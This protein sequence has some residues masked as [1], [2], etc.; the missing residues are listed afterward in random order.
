MS[1][2]EALTQSKPRQ[3][4]DVKDAALAAAAN[5]I[6]ITDHE[7]VIE[8][9]NPA[10]TEMTGYSAEEVIG[11]KTSILKSGK[12]NQTY[13]DDLW[14]TVKTGKVWRGDLINRRKNGG[15]YIE[16]MTIT[17][18][19]NSEDRIT[20]YIAIKQDVTARRTVENQLEETRT[21]MNSVLNATSEA[22]ILLSTD[23]CALWMN[24]AF[25]RI[26]NVKNSQLYG[27]SF[28]ELVPIFEKVI[29]DPT[30]IKQRFEKAQETFTETVQQVWPQKRELEIYAVPVS[31]DKMN[32]GRLYVFRDVTKERE[33]ERMK[34]DFIHL[35]SHEFRTPLTS[36]KGYVEML[37]D[38]DA[39]NVNEDQVDFLD[40][41]LRNTDL[42]AKL[43]NDLLE[44]SK[45]EAGALKLDT[46]PV[47]LSKIIKEATV[48]M[49]PQIQEKSQN[50]V[51]INELE[52]TTV[53]GDPKKLTQILLNLL[54]NANKYTPEKGKITVTTERIK[55]MVKVTVND[56]G[57]G[58]SEE[59]QKRLFTKFF[60]VENR[61]T[62]RHPG[63][64]LGLWITKS[65]VDM[66]GGT[67]NIQSKIEEGTAI[68]F[69]IPAKINH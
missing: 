35:V 69:T 26:F 40:T 18:V 3:E 36:I 47:D 46:Q 22:M 24:H 29:Q 57:I 9:V 5:S 27:K 66:H 38:G 23:D 53:I 28:E 7:G 39:G 19:V 30:F 42:L 33:V 54:S 45:L 62:Q 48:E 63:T 37:L 15:N 1:K 31:R 59:D 32:L 20:H 68:S 21:I 50:L 44:V 11:K 51:I 34:T 65:F 2:G 25:E 43:V 8:W 60:R 56:N 13:Y 52:S 17:P 12:Q 49:I 61:E 64:G 67:I 58:I 4:N 55:D 41:I 10:F 16:E 6:E 14:S